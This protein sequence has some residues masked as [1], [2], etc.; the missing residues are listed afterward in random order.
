[1]SVL[2]T[3]ILSASCLAP[4]AEPSE[5]QA[6]AARPTCTPW[7]GSGPANCYEVKGAWFDGTQCWEGGCL[8]SAD[9]PGTFDSFAECVAT[10]EVPAN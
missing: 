1:M 8:S 2:L 4:V 10:C 5:S 6:A 9:G 3:L 7:Q